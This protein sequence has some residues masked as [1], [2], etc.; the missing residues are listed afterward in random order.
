MPDDR[1]VLEVYER[2][3]GLNGW[4]VRECCLCLSVRVCV[5]VCVRR[6]GTARLLQQGFSRS[7]GRTAIVAALK[8]GPDWIARFSSRGR[9]LHTFCVRACVERHPMLRDVTGR[10]LKSRLGTREG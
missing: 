4:R 10:E 5:C 8:P 9:V 2:E 3:R 6:V 1:L 7:L